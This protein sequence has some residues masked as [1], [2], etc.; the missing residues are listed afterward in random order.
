[1][2]WRQRLEIYLE[3]IDSPIGRITNL[4]I[5][6]LVLLS[7]TIFVLQTY[8]LPEPVRH[9]LNGLDTILL[10][11]F[12]IEYVLRL[13]CA[14]FR[15][16]YI[17]SV[18]SLIDLLAILPSFLVATDVSFLRSL[19]V[20]RWFRILRLIRFLE[21]RILFNRFSSEESIAL[22]RILFTL[23][24]I[25]FIFSGLIYQ[26][27]HS[28]NPD[29]FRTFFDAFYF[30]VVTMTTVGFGDVTPISE[31]GRLLTVVMIL[32][33]VTLIPWQLSTLVKELIKAT[34]SQTIACSRCGHAL[35]DT[36]AKFCKLCGAPLSPPSP[37]DPGQS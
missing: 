21:G 4:T 10:L 32:T 22:V 27:E 33:G 14:Q 20:F 2:S 12:T 17:L 30:S 18:Y 28:H 8:S 3:D 15:C 23:F 24:T 34:S 11:I 36:D 16:Q 31:A 29:I 25:I 7:S 1:M 35:H 37:P 26:T 6:S 9:I 5:A 13:W 19:R